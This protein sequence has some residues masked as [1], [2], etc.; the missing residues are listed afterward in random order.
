[1]STAP[2]T[3]QPDL[4]R[5]SLVDLRDPLEADIAYR[6]AVAWKEMRR[7]AATARLRDYFLGTGT[8]GVDQGQMDTLDVLA[9]RTEWR[10]SE[11]ADALRVDPSTATRAVQR[12]VAAGLAER[13]AS[14][15]DGRVVMVRLSANGSKQHSAVSKRRVIAMSRLLGGFDGAERAQL[16]GLLERFV[17]RIDELVV[18]LGGPQDPDP[19]QGDHTTRQ[20][21]TEATKTI[22]D[23]AQL[24]HNS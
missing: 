1:M 14:G 7:G 2:A 13:Q 3:E 11:L 20:L 23:R 12:V 15:D 10:M 19:A 4:P 22:S 9:T 21:T 16:A 18:E 5:P 6:I 8:E 24:P 17:A